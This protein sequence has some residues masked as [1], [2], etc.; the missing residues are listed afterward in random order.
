MAIPPGGLASWREPAP[1]VRAPVGRGDDA[2][3]RRAEA[4]PCIRWSG[5]SKTNPRPARSCGSRSAPRTSHGRWRVGWANCRNTRYGHTLRTAAGG[6]TTRQPRD[7][8]RSRSHWAE[9]P[10]RP[11]SS[12]LYLRHASA[13]GTAKVSEEDGGLIPR[14]STAQGHGRSSCAPSDP[15]CRVCGSEAGPRLRARKHRDQGLGPVG[16]HDLDDEG[17]CRGLGVG[18]D[19]AGVR[20]RMAEHHR[21][22]AVPTAHAD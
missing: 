12:R 4:L 17:Q 3:E 15:A 7:T 22:A 8:P 16:A 1:M 10:G 20:D 11:S 18:Q 6:A 21:V 13:I 2:P 14:R 19:R 9:S 5:S